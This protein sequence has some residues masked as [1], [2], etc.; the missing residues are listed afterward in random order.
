[1]VRVI[2]FLAFLLALALGLAWIA[3][4]P[5]SEHRERPAALFCSAGPGLV[6]GRTCAAA[7]DARPTTRR[8]AHRASGECSGRVL[9]RSPSRGSA[10]LRR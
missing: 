5:G 6:P 1:M 3:D 2:A 4:R 10:D 8:A 7:T 9:T